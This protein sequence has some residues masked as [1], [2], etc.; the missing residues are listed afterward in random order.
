MLITNGDGLFHQNK[1]GDTALHAAAWKSKVDAVNLLLSSGAD[2][3]LINCE[4]KTALELAT[5]PEIIDLLMKEMGAG[6]SVDC[7]SDYFGDEQHSD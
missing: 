7:Q 3:S 2:A 4:G 1:L 6:S 5:D